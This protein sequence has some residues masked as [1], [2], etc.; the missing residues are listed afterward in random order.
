M[1]LITTKNPEKGKTNIHYTSN[2]SVKQPLTVPD[3]VTD[4]YT[5]AKM[6]AE[7]FVN[8]DGSFPQ[9]INKEMKFSQAYLDEFK[10]RVESGQPYNEVEVDPTTGEYIYYGST[11]WYKELYKKATT[12]YDNNISVSGSGD[13]AAYM[14]SGRMMKQN[15]IFRYNTDDYTMFN[16]RAK[17]NVQVFP[18]LQIENNTEYSEMEYYNP[19]AVGEGTIDVWNLI[20]VDTHP[21]SPMFNPDGTLTTGAVY[22]VG[23]L[24]YGKNGIGLEKSVLKNTSGFTAKFFED[25][26][27]VKG[28]FTFRNSG[29]NTV[30]K[31]V[32]VPYSS[33]PGVILYVGTAT[34]DLQ[35]DW[36][37]TKYIATN[38]YGEFENTFKENHYFKLM[39]GTNYEQ[40]TYNRLSVT[41]NG[42][43]FEDATDINLALGQAI[44]TAGGWEKWVILGGFSRLNYSFKD[45]YLLEVN[46]RYDGSSKFPTNQRYAFFPSISAGWRIS[47]E[48]FWTISPE[49]ISNL[50]LRASYGSLGNGN[51]GSYIYQE[52]FSISQS[53]EHPERAVTA[54]YPES[55]CSSRRDYLGDLHNHRY[56]ARLQYV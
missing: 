6:F 37:D 53:S 14:V 44:T 8:G 38:L 23:D 35:K 3:F 5:F 46:A 54:V 11:D 19:I 36:R 10:R 39:A 25:K 13:K 22:S 31:R 28:D 43:I 47:N 20:G 32:P 52:Q 48:S 30:T 16:L 42:L 17:G 34:N 49:I 12:A 41:R 9:N 4:G 51:I 15:G 26:F 1:I 29:N 55:N 2:F 33:K 24:W 18:W 27:R 56:R 7:S 45:K 21:T 40:S 50:K